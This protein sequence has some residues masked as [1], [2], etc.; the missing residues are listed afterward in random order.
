MRKGK[1][2][3]ISGPSGAGKTSIL[4]KVLNNIPGIEFSVSCTTR[5]KRKN[6]INGKDY[7]FISKENFEK[8]IKSNYFLEWAEVHEHY[9]GT[10][11][12]FVN[13]KINEGIDL[14]LDIDVQGG[15]N[16]MKQNLDA[17]TIFIS[18]PSY[19]ELKER[20]VSRKTECD[21]DIEIRLKN[22]RWEMKEFT[23]FKY[24]LT[25]QSLNDSIKKLES[26][27]IAERLILEKSQYDDILKKIIGG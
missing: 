24:F 22:A 23:K 7:F 27:I 8:K 2:F 9:Y 25:N 14:I 1:L 13:M 10:S 6:E 16:V 17:V 18:P 11:K 21:K 26:I 19:E 4:Y 3:V 5:E 12:E 20:L 15:L